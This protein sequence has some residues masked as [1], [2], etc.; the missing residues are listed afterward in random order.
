MLIPALLDSLRPAKIASALSSYK[1]ELS[2]E[3]NG[4][5]GSHQTK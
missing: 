2:I 3:R 1:E 4:T 5:S